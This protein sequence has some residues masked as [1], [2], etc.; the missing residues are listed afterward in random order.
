MNI[1]KLLTAL[2]FLAITT[3]QAQSTWKLDA[4]HSS[5]NFAVSHLVISETTGSFDQ[6]DI[7]AITEEDFKNPKFEVAIETASI[8]TKNERRDNHLRADDFFG[9]EKFPKITFKSTSFEKVDD[10]TFK[11]TGDLTIKGITKKVTFNGK[12]NGI[13]KSDR[14]QKA[15]LK[16]NTTIKRTD[17]KVGSSGGS[18]GEDVTVTINL[19]MAKK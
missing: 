8:N 19:E 18:V 16:L 7:T 9:A 17:F 3:T 1:K 6:F 11:T 12:L 2:L 14:G 5:I 10:K 15:G 4:G 13:L